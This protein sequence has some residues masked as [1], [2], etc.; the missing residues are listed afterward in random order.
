MKEII[1]AL[2][3]VEAG[4]RFRKFIDERGYDRLELCPAVEDFVSELLAKWHYVAVATRD[5]YREVSGV[6]GSIVEQNLNRFILSPT[7]RQDT[8][9]E[10]CNEQAAP[11]YDPTVWKAGEEIIATIG[12]H[13]R[14]NE[15]LPIIQRVFLRGIEEGFCGGSQWHPDTIE[16]MQAQRE[17]ASAAELARDH[18]D[19]IARRQGS[20]FVAKDY[21]AESLIGQSFVDRQKERGAKPSNPEKYPSHRTTAAA[22]L[23]GSRPM[24]PKFACPPSYRSTKRTEYTYD[25]AGRVSSCMETHSD[26]PEG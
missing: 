9:N 12:D 7:I 23:S 19:R 8:W 18:I 1:E 13:P 25:D 6:N 26:F 10:Y 3:R 16:K 20:E 4:Q 17:Q 21:G 15:I 11:V 24:D 14:P 2:A 5:A 22:D